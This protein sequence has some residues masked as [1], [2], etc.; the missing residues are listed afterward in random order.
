MLQVKQERGAHFVLMQPLDG[1]LLISRAAVPV[2]VLFGGV[3]PP[4]SRAC[5]DITRH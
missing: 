5:F 1:Q 3:V 2:V 4:G